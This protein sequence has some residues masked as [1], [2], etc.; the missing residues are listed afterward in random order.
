[1][2]SKTLDK[3]TQSFICFSIFILWYFISYI[4]LFLSNYKALYQSG[5]LIPFMSF[6]L[7]LPFSYIVVKKYSIHYKDIKKGSVDIKSTALFILFIFILRFVS[8]FYD[9]PEVWVE[10]I[11]SYSNFSFFLLS[12]CVCFFSPIYEEIIFRGF[13]LNAFLS[14]GPKA[15]ICGIVLTSI[16]FSLV[17]T[18]YNSPTTFIELFTFS[19]ILCYARIYKNGLLFPILLHCIFNSFAT[20]LIILSR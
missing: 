6:A 12:I 17:H 19:V 5:Y 14:W 13:L 20:L 2:D 16:L 8:V 3:I 9:K 18:Q 7:W 15:K 10:S 1:M 11:T 4:S